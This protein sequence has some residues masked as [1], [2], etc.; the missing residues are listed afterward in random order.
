MSTC[1]CPQCCAKIEYTLTK[2]KTC[3]KCK[4][5]V[6]AAFKVEVK[7]VV[8]TA[9]PVIAAQVITSAPKAVTSAPYKN[10]IRPS[11]LTD[12]NGN[13]VNA[14]NEDAYDEYEV[15]AAAQRIL[16]N[17]DSSSFFAPVGRNPDIM[18]FKDA[19]Q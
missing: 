4:K 6:E 19:I 16:A 8:V 1:Y 9:K 17:I 14:S 10:V 5:S 12:E 7:P 13:T 11:K 3:P 18:S 15:Q 2:P